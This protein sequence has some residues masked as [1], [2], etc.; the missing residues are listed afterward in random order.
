MT[1]KLLLAMLMA[2]LAVLIWQLGS[3]WRRRPGSR[4][5]SQDTQPRA[6]K[7]SPRLAQRAA[8]DDV[9]QPPLKRERKRS[10]LA[11]HANLDRSS[12]AD[13]LLKS[14]LYNEVESKLTQAFEH[15][16]KAWFRLTVMKRWFELKARWFTASAP[17]S[18]LGKWRTIHRPHCWMNCA[19]MSKPLRLRSSGV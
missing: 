2:L 15:F 12:A 18:E 14:G 4:P 8:L 9:S 1:P 19:R 5:V 3:L 7:E 11:I 6:V 17:N 13:A 10:L 16:A